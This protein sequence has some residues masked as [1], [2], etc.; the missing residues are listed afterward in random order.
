[1]H[2]VSSSNQYPQ[3]ALQGEP[4]ELRELQLEL[5]LLGDV[6]LVG[7]PSVGK[8]TLI[9]AI[10]N[11]KAATAAYHFTTIVP[12]LG[13]VNHKGKDFSVVDIPGLIE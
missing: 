6:A 11:V 2:F 1:M 10:S 5:Q 7:T 13:M 3:I 9:N 4:G 8:S 12:N